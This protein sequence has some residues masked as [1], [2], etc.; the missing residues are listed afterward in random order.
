MPRLVSSILFA[1]L[2]IAAHPVIGVETVRFREEGLSN[3]APLRS[4]EARTVV[5]EI[6]VE[7][8]D[9]G[10]MLQGDDGRIWSIQPHQ[11]VDRKSSDAELVPISADEMVKRMLEELPAGFQV[12]RTNDYVIFHNTTDAYV[13]EVGTLFQQLHRGFF[14]YWK[15]QRWELPKP[16]FP[17]VALVL[18]GRGDFLRHAEPEIGDTAKNVIGYYHLSSNRMTTYNVV[19]NLERTVATI[20]H[21]AT[22]Q[23]AYNCG[24][25][26]RFADNPMWVSEGLAT[27]FESP[28]MRNPRKWRSIGRVNQFNL[29]RWRNYVGRRPQESLATLLADDNR[30]RQSSTAADAYAES[31]ALTYFLIKTRRQEY[32]EYLR[33][34]SEGRPLV[35]RTRRQ[36]IE[37]FEETF[38]TSVVDIDRALVNYMR[39]VR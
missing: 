18:S 20:I 12:Y 36:R 29:A 35:E 10:L 7:A 3:G 17:L 13:R 6:L 26:R 32:V 38:G 1:G 27:F 30:L 21:E 22:H 4:G 24:L 28:D 9:G 25:Q 11:I 14:T 16:R 33:K 39:R 31:W 19:P 5:G 37:M 34:L 15:N 8:A 23:L 2:A